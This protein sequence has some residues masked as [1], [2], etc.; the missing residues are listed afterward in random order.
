MGLVIMF[1]K[2]SFILKIFVLFSVAGQIVHSEP[3]TTNDPKPVFNKIY[4]NTCGL[5]YIPCL[6]AG[7]ERTIAKDY[8][9]IITLGMMLEGGGNYFEFREESRGELK[10]K[11]LAVLGNFA[12][13]TTKLML[14]E[15]SDFTGV[16]AGLHA[17]IFWQKVYFEDPP[18]KE[19]KLIASESINQQFKPVV[20]FEGGYAVRSDSL[21][22]TLG[23]RIMLAEKFSIGY[24]IHSDEKDYTSRA[25]ISAISYPFA[26]TLV[27]AV[28]YVF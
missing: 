1:R 4:I 25:E 22:F 24:N 9:S 13:L 6:E 8:N 27:A 21:V 2:I 14:Y 18:C 17:G 12:I 15:N 19:C 26:G 10:D 3:A 23:F 28:G 16:Y 5:P 20:G 11:G 7:Y